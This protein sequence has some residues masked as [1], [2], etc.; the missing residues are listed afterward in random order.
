MSFQKIIR[1]RIHVGTWGIGHDSWTL[2]QVSLRSTL[3]LD[4]FSHRTFFKIERYTLCVPFVCIH[5]LMNTM[6]KKNVDSEIYIFQLLDVSL[7]STFR[8]YFSTFSR[9]N[10]F[11]WKIYSVCTFCM[12]SLPYKYNE[13]TLNFG[14]KWLV[15]WDENCVEIFFLNLD[16]KLLNASETADRQRTKSDG[17]IN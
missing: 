16:W 8:G 2:F 13:K 15:L 12:Y 17:K 4:T 6:E 3:F 11:N 7:R 14:L 10:F 5:Y 1:I 9:R